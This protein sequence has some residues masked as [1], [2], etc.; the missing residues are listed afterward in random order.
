MGLRSEDREKTAF[1]TSLGLFHFTVLPFYLANAPS[2]DIFRSLNCVALL[3]YMDDIISPCQS[4]DQGLQRLRNIFDR[5]RDA[6]LKLKPSKC[7]FGQKQARF[8]EHI[9]SESG[10]ST[11]P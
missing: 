5:M 6:N 8:L 10:V 4:V 11:D 7:T 1:A 3:L 9:V 2:T